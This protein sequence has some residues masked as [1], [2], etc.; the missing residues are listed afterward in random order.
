M[1]E[2]VFHCLGQA[3]ALVGAVA[4]ELLWALPF[5]AREVRGW[6]ARAASIPDAELRITAIGVLGDKRANSDGSALFSILAPRR[7]P[8]LLRLLLTYELMA[9]LLDDLDEH[10]AFADVLSGRELHSATVAALD[11]DRPVRDYYL[12]RLNDN[13]YLH[14]LLGASREH[15]ASLPSYGHIGP[16]A[17]RVAHQAQVQAIN[18]Y[19]DPHWR[20]VALM[21]WAGREFP[22]EDRLS[23][24]ELAG[25]ASGWL[26]VYALLA[27]ASEP[28]VGERE[29]GQTYTSY[30][31]IS[32]AGTML[33]SFGDLGEDLA[34]GAHSYIAHYPT[35]DIAARR[36]A[37][38]LRESTYRARTLRNGHRH[39]VIVACMMAMYLSKDGIRDPGRCAM[40]ERLL[41]AGG[42]LTRLLVPV[43]R[44]W[45]IAYGQQ[46]A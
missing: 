16:L 38:F 1:Y 23:W 37:Q 35:Q 20:D 43:L 34:S 2:S 41:R 29:G 10:P 44:L 30:R 45:R 36:V 3:R 22:E 26:G 7:D 5:V 25:A 32:L 4:H 46:S 6:Q 18:H 27:L 39:S 14:A 9:D 8:R 42:P 31:W 12:G 33:D 40:T 15:V 17:I 21:R 24:F 13:G 11:F 19:A 28:T